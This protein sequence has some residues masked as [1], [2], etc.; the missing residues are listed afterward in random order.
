[1]PSPKFNNEVYGPIPKATRESRWEKRKYRR[2]DAGRIRRFETSQTRRRALE[3]EALAFGHL[4]ICAE[5][6]TLMDALVHGKYVD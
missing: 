3:I 2:V 6:E 4:D 1:M 5:C